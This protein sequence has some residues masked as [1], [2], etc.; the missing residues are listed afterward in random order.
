MDGF[1]QPSSTSP[2]NEQP[3]TNKR[4]A[5]R[6]EWARATDGSYGYAASLGQRKRVAHIPTAATEKREESGLK[7]LSKRKRTER[8]APLYTLISTTSGPTDGVHLSCGR[9]IAS[10]QGLLAMTDGSPL[11]RSP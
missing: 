1:L 5:R 10:S 3:T 9:W 7:I 11:T 4:L 6:H 8:Q 2:I